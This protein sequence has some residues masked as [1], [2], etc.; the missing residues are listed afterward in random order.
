MT[1]TQLVQ[2]NFVCTLWVAVL[3]GCPCSLWFCIFWAHLSDE[4]LSLWVQGCSSTSLIPAWLSSN[5]PSCWKDSSLFPSL[6]NR[7]LLFKP[8]SKSF[9][10]ILLLEM[11]LKVT[12]AQ[13]RRDPEEQC[14]L[15]NTMGFHCAPPG[16][17]ILVW[18]ERWWLS[19]SSVPFQWGAGS[20]TGAWDSFVT[21]DVHKHTKVLVSCLICLLC[22]PLSED[23]LLISYS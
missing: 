7:Q 15:T 1:R 3:T 20:F 5:S 21:K 22:V 10:S 12:E 6:W 8:L 16:Q 11:C 9:C 14:L 13:D 19:E 17:E 23:A 2:G 4:L 18:Q